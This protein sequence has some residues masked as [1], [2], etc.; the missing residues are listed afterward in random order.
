MSKGV[1]CFGSVRSN[2]EK[3]EE[4]NSCIRR[5]P[6][7]AFVINGKELWDYMDLG[8]HTLKVQGREYAAELIGRMISI[9]R[10]MIDAHREGKSFDD[11]AMVQLQSELD[12]IGKDRDRAR[13]QKT[14]E[15]QANIKGLFA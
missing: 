13:R 14:S 9:Y 6:N 10:T 15:L 2:N 1:K 5:N 11:P 3:I 4:I 7:V 12:L 8:L